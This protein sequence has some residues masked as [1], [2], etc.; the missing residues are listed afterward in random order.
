MPV[1]GRKNPIFTF[2]DWE[3]GP[4]AEVPVAGGEDVLPELP[5]EVVAMLGGVPIAVFLTVWISLAL[6]ARL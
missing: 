6:K 5:L 3:I 4:L 1:L 2:P